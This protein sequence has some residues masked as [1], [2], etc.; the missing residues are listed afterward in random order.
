[1]GDGSTGTVRD[2]SELDLSHVSAEGSDATQRPP[3]INKCANVYVAAIAPIQIVEAS[4]GGA[5]RRTPRQKEDLW[6]FQRSSAHRG[7]FEF[8]RLTVLG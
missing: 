4:W 2:V 3:R 8:F 5:C 7:L 6:K 1:V